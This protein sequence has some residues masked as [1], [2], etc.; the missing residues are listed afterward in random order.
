MTSDPTSPRPRHPV[1]RVALAAGGVGIG[2]V[3]CLAGA[4]FAFWAVSIFSGASGASATAQTLP[5][6]A[7]P[8]ATV[9]PASNP[10]V[11]IAFTQS[12]SSGGSAL[13][14]YNVTRYLM[15][16]STGVPISGSCA[17]AATIVCT[18]TPGA[19]TWLY[20]DTPTIGT[21]WTGTESPRSSAVIVEALTTTSVS[22]PASGIAGATLA[23]AT[24]TL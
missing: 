5:T 1:R 22:A 12:F 15:G 13:T 16:S 19:G 6:G 14:A 17:P 3:L 18:D 11:S 2:L 4:A 24:A 21:N 20:T 23:A 8:V 7:T 9:S 10:T